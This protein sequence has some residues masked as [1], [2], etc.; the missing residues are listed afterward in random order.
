MNGRDMIQARQV[1]QQKMKERRTKYDLQD[2]NAVAA[3]N[4]G[5]ALA[6]DFDNFENNE[7]GALAG[8]GVQD[9]YNDPS[10][11][12]LNNGMGV[13]E[14]VDEM[15]KQ[16][17]MI[18]KTGAMLALGNADNQVDDEQDNRAMSEY[19]AELFSYAPAIL[20]EAI[21]NGDQYERFKLA[22]KFAFSVIHNMALQDVTQKKPIIPIIGESYEGLYVMP[23]GQVNIYMESDYNEILYKDLLTGQ[24]DQKIK[25]DQETTYIHIEGPKGQF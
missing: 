2:D 22:I 1:D 14:D 4:R 21:R 19:Y 10:Y 23:D 25:K 5:M 24:N 16:N 7:F 8:G 15:R 9:L 3:Q 12:R 13:N 17:K 6:S 11:Q 18:A 20:S